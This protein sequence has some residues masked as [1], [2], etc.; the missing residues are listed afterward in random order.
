MIGQAELARLARNTAN[1]AAPLILIRGG[2]KYETAP[3]VGAD[4]AV[5][6]KP[7]QNKRAAQIA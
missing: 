7:E 5:S 6:R 4:S 3:S 2:R 1:N